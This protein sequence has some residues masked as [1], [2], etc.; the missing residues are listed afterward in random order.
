MDILS[1]NELNN[2]LDFRSWDHYSEESGWLTPVAPA[3]GYLLLLI[4]VLKVGVYFTMRFWSSS[5]A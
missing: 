2:N 1:W 4:V 5:K 3:I